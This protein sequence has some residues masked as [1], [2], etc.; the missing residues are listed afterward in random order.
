[1]VYVVCSTL[2]RSRRAR[3]LSH[4]WDQDGTHDSYLDPFICRN[5]YKR[6]L[7]FGIM[8]MMMIMVMTIN[9]RMKRPGPAMSGNNHPDDDQ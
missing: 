8:M 1:M 4:K 2:S 6:F 3:S 7:P 9:N 5:Q